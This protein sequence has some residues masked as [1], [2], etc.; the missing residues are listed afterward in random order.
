MKFAFSPKIFLTQ[1]G[2]SL[3]FGFGIGILR[4]KR[5][6]RFRRTS[7]GARINSKDAHPTFKKFA[8]SIQDEIERTDFSKLYIQPKLIKFEKDSA[9]RNIVLGEGNFG[10][11]LLATIFDYMVCV[12]ECK[13]VL[14]N[15]LVI[16]VSQF[17][18]YLVTDCHRNNN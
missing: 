18:A 9:G 11:A 12:K 8:S 3:L 5:K 15:Y 1:P 10:R 17:V 4:K 6:K 16:K 14:L 7:Y 2:C 13:G